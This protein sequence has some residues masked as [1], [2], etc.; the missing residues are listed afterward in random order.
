MVGYTTTQRIGAV[1]VTAISIGAVIA[2]AIGILIAC[3]SI[4]KVFYTVGGITVAVCF[5][6][7]VVFIGATDFWAGRGKLCKATFT[8]HV[9]STT[10][11]Q[12]LD[13][14]Y[15]GCVILDGCRFAFEGADIANTFISCALTCDR[16]PT[17]RRCSQR[18]AERIGCRCLGIK[19]C[20]L[21]AEPFVTTDV[22]GTVIAYAVGVFITCG[23]IG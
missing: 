22:V 6:C 2:D 15:A 23:S 13:V 4:G 17:V 20:G 11:V 5:A 21:T 12:R 1:V 3:R 7:V 9:E 8:I 10:A 19:I 18:L 14:G 16:I